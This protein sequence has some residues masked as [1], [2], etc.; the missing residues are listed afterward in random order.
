MEKYTYGR[1]SGKSKY[2]NFLSKLFLSLI[3]LGIAGFSHA[4]T[5]TWFQL[6]NTAPD[7]NMGVMMLMTDGTVI[8]HNSSGGG[9]G[10]GWDKLTPDATGSYINGTW[11]TIASMANDRLFFPSQIMP[12]GEVLWQEENMVQVPH[13]VNFI[14]R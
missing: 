3:T 6:N 14:I 4:Q 7:F 9:V 2:R 8:A 13:M 1:V 10:K 5:G 11:T 12:N